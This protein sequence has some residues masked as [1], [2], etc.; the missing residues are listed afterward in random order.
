MRALPSLNSPFNDVKLSG[1]R[2]T[3]EIFEAVV[4]SALLDPSP[5][6]LL[7]STKKNILNEDL[8]NKQSFFAA[9]LEAVSPQNLC[10]IGRDNLE[11]VSLFSVLVEMP[12]QQKVRGVRAFNFMA[13][14]SSER[15]KAA[16]ENRM[17]AIRELERVYAF[18]L[19]AANIKPRL[20]YFKNYADVLFRRN[21]E[22][23]HMFGRPLF[24]F[25]NEFVGLMGGLEKR[26]VSVIFRQLL[27]KSPRKD[28]IFYCQTPEI[29]EGLQQ[30]VIDNPKLLGRRTYLTP[31][32]SKAGSSL[33]LG[34]LEVPVESES[35]FVQRMKKIKE[36]IQH[37]KVTEEI[38]ESRAS[39]KESY[40]LSDDS[41]PTM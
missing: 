31:V 8:T 1:M 34:G 41:E 3:K 5:D 18:T 2:T 37:S 7:S 22:T 25:D 20:T 11:G 4:D 16:V 19:R 33:V 29:R 13:E 23:H 36:E 38:E 14:G 26:E 9:S 30:G 40:S 6:G 17:R 10:F 39:S 35:E 27:E 24:T 15:L 21:P 28:F 12:F 32:A